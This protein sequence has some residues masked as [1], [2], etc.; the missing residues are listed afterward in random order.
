VLGINGVVQLGAAPVNINSSQIWRHVSIGGLEGWI[1]A[2]DLEPL[3]L[4]QSGDRST[5]SKFA[6]TE[7]SAK[8]L[9]LP[10]YEKKHST[11]SDSATSQQKKFRV[12]L[13]NLA[14]R[15]MPD[16]NS[17]AVKQLSEGQIV[18]AQSM[19][20]EGSWRYVEV[21]GLQGWVAAQWLKPMH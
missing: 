11:A 8:L 2:S 4:N 10:V 18:Q 19:A 21:D 14:L 15:V 13:N 5:V 6:Q 1:L 20:V 7:R 3:A 9:S 16:I 17:I 12:Q